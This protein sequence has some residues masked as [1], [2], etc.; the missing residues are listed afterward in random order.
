MAWRRERF[1]E[2]LEGCGE[3]EPHSRFRV[4]AQLYAC[5]GPIFPPAPIAAHRW[6]LGTSTDKPEDDDGECGSRGSI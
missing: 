4:S 6:I 5:L 2:A 1:P 3:V